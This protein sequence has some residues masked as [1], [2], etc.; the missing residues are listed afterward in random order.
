MSDSIEF[1]VPVDERNKCTEFKPFKTIG[2]IPYPNCGKRRKT[3]PHMR[4]FWAATLAFMM[5]FIGWFAFAPLMVV[6]RK[7]I[8]LCDNDAE[9]QA[10]IEN[11]KCVCKT[12]CKATI[13][14]ANIAAVLFDVF[15]RFIL[16]AVIER[17]GPV[18]T[19]VVLLL[20]GSIVVGASAAVTNGTGLIIVRFFVSA[21][22]STFVVNQF[23]NSILFA[24]SVVGTANATAGGWGNLGGGLTQTLMP[25]VYKFW[26]D[27]CGFS[28]SASWRLAMAVPATI[29]L[30]LAV[31]IYFCSQDMTTGKFNIAA[32]GKSKKADCKQYFECL[33]DYRV[34]LMIFQYGACFGCELV[35]N[36]K[37][38][39][40]FSDYFGVDLVYAGALAMSFGAMN[41]FARSLGGI[42]SDW[43]SERFGMPGRLWVHFLSLLGQAVFLFG[44]GLIDKDMGWPWA[45]FMVVMM[46]IFVNAAEGTSYGI[47]PYMI[48]Q[49]LAI[50]SAMV[51]AGG[52]LGAVIAL[53]F[54]YRP[55]WVPETL[56]GFKIHGAFVLFWA[57]T[58]PLMRWDHL[59]SML[60]RPASLIAEAKAAAAVGGQAADQAEGNTQE[61]I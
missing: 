58:V 42:A 11:A 43:A 39:M 18:T 37:L 21:L 2:P 55:E 47:V 38:A 1:E 40:H 59:G 15:T 26:H 7:D 51:G 4:G 32:L 3:N 25:L 12:D 17:L 8:G 9:V 27:A 23:W 14:N 34:F 22:G 5:A 44:F 61:A 24:P 46:A 60:G 48:P 41:L 16:G 56:D 20:F 36:T 28:L 19:D 57:L 53:N 13:N 45:L 52:T 6:V 29:F 50:V 31:W 35:M 10:D 54:F 49:H 30:L 33:I